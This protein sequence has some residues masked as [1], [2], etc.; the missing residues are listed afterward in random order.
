YIVI[1][2]L[3]VSSGA[4]ALDFYFAQLKMC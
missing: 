3:D 1:F 2:F 4:L